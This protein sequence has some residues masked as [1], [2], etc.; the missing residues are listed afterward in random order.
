MVNNKHNTV[1]FGAALVLLASGAPMT[2]ADDKPEATPVGLV[3]ATV[4]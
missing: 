2:V 1:L 4:L 3:K